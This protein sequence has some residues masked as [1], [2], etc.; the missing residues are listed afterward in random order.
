MSTFAEHLKRVLDKGLDIDALI[1]EYPRLVQQG[2]HLHGSWGNAVRAYGGVGRFDFQIAPIRLRPARMAVA[3]RLVG[4]AAMH[5][6]VS[7]K[8]VKRTD[9]ALSAEVIGVFGSAEKLARR[10]G[11]ATVG[12]FDPEEMVVCRICDKEFTSLTSHISRIHGMSCQEYKDRFG[13]DHIVA[14][15]SRRK[16]SDGDVFEPLSREEVL[17]K[18]REHVQANPKLTGSWLRK[19]DPKLERQV[20][21][22]WESWAEV[23]EI[24]GLK[25]PQEVWSP[26]KIL[27]RVRGYMKRNNLSAVCAADILKYDARLYGAILRRYSNWEIFVGVLGLDLDACRRRRYWDRESVLEALRDWS[28]A[29]GTVVSSRLLETDS[30]LYSAILAYCGSLQAAAEALGIPFECKSGETWTPALVLER[31]RELHKPGSGLLTQAAAD[32]VYPTLS[33]SARRFFGGWPKA[34][35]A[36]GIDETDWR[37]DPRELSRR[38]RE[39]MSEHGDLRSTVLRD[40]DPIL[41]GALQRKYRSLEIAAKALGVPYE[42]PNKKWT[43]ETLAQ[44]LREM[45]EEGVPMAG[46][47]LKENHQGIRVAIRK[48]FGTLQEALDYA[49]V[50]PP[51]KPKRKSKK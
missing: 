12:D 25:P 17:E 41:A 29:N 37:K 50:K 6:P 26:R 35:E 47:Y 22:L 43:K 19:H 20:R 15:K 38:L 39:W 34:K 49:G 33:N 5:G 48:V 2:V 21:Y 45:A 23:Y 30:G 28:A 32:A 27:A 9:P 31:I 18:L 3:G 44:R 16:L 13:V 4:W 42:Q 40:T 8:A 7:D 1:Q 36:A 11:I 51:R 24:L 14:P 10:L 46:G